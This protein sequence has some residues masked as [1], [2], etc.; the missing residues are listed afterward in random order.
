[1]HYGDQRR[2]FQETKLS[3]GAAVLVGERHNN[4]IIVIRN[5][6]HN[7]S[8]LPAIP[9]PEIKKRYLVLEQLAIPPQADA[10]GNYLKYTMILKEK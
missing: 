9:L 3:F 10:P 8:T 2:L 7:C 6:P 4:G 1:M 5:T